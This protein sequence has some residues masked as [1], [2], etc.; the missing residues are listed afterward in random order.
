M[1]HEQQQ[2]QQQ[3]PF[4]QQQNG[5]MAMPPPPPAQPED[6]QSNIT[7]SWDD[8]RQGQNPFQTAREYAAAGGGGNHG[9]SSSNTGRKNGGYQ[10]QQQQQQQPNAFPRNPYHQQQPPQ[11]TVIEYYADYCRICQRAALA[12]QK[13]ASKARKEDWGVQFCKLEATQHLEH[14]QLKELDIPMFPYVHVYYG[15]RRV[16]SLRAVPV[17]Q[18]QDNLMAVLQDCWDKTEGDWKAYERDYASELQEQQASRDAVRQ[19]IQLA[20]DKQAKL[21]RRCCEHKAVKE[22]VLLFE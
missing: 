20:A 2:Q 19:E 3:Q 5:N 8:H 6:Q 18:L 16:A 13:I 7:Q 14:S 17:A 1:Q 4:R 15:E 10:Y 22:I 21:M 11:L 12:Y 9:S